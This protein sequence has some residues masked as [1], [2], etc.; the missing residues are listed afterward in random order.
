V[1]ATEAMQLFTALQRMGIPSKFV[2]FPDEG[3]GV[4]KPL[5]SEFWHKTVFDWLKQYIG[6]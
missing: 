3:H 2:Y 6:S 5:N 4:L 1:P